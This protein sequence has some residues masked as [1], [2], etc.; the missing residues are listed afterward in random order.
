MSRALDHWH[1]TQNPASY[2][3]NNDRFW[4][5]E[6]P[7][8]WPR[9]RI[10]PVDQGLQFAFE[11]APRLC[12]ELNHRR[13]PFGCH[14]WMNSIREF[15]KPHIVAAV[16]K[17]AARQT[18]RTALGNVCPDTAPGG[19]VSLNGP[20]GRHGPRAP[21]SRGGRDHGACRA[22]GLRG[23][24]PV[25][26]RGC[27][28]HGTPNPDIRGRGVP[29][30]QSKVWL[31]TKPGFANGSFEAEFQGW[32]VQGNIGVR[33]SDP[34]R[35]A[36]DGTSVVVFNGGDEMSFDASLAQT[37]ATTVGQ[38]YGLAFDLWYRRSRCRPIVAGDRVRQWRPVRQDRSRCRSEPGSL[39]CPSAAQLHCKRFQDHLTFTE[40]SY[41]YVVIDGLL[42]NVRI[43]EESVDLPLV[44]SDPM[45]TAV[46]QGQAATFDVQAS[47]PG[48]LVVSVG[49]Q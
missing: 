9:F 33:T 23:R 48:T 28:E 14:A 30:G 22:L 11:A 26:R 36:P 15:W 24:M 43:T 47:G 13:L 1:A 21:V 25:E 18:R 16:R 44:A 20:C 35:P 2:G 39:L 31:I 49:V 10:A 5:Y 32:T 40:K 8:Y 37:F 34:V 7:R 6:A 41:T 19:P 29:L 42:D 3:R 45:S 27:Q 12:F 38:R 17:P 46:A 4:S